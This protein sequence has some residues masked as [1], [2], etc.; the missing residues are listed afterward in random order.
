M[1]G[2]G[3]QQH[4]IYPIFD[5]SGRQF[6]GPGGARVRARYPDYR[7]ALLAGRITRGEGPLESGFRS[8][9]EGDL[10]WLYADHEVGVVGRA[11]VSKL[12]GRP[13]PWVTFTLDRPASRVLAQD[14]LTGSLLRRGF[15]GVIDGP[16]PL[17]D[18]P[19][20]R[21]GLEW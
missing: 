19:Q 10:L 16:A 14:P 6:L 1:T 21:E 18:H 8:I 7:R 2:T 15:T 20:A 3:R 9:R 12:T 4:W 11:R 13:A 5:G 17:A